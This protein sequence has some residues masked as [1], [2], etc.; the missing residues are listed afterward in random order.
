[1]TKRLKR[2][3][4]KLYRKYRKLPKAKQEAGRDIVERAAVDLGITE[5]ELAEKYQAGGR[6]KR[7]VREAL[8]A[9]AS[10]PSANIEVF[11][12]AGERDWDNFWTNFMECFAEFL[13]LILAI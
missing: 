3:E 11:A 12:K 10:R 4:R 13:P 9:A 7:E 6:G 1:M 5:A 2:R 8:Q